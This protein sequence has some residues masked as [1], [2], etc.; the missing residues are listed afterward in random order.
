VPAALAG[1]TAVRRTGCS[2]LTG[3]SSSP[4]S[5]NK[6]PPRV[7][8]VDDAR[9]NREAY[10]E[11]LR[12]RG[13]EVLEASTGAE[14]VQETA[15][16]APDVVLLDMRLPDTNGGQV[17]REL[18]AMPGVR[19]TII[20]VSACT[21]ESDVSAALESGCDAFLAKPCLP[22]TLEKE[23]RRHLRARAVA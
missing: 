10:A 11:Y 17:C 20:A 6:R 4:V 3:M 15:R 13:F 12:F 21:F 16:S 19:P 23:I 14:A 5:N 8:I 18:R 7:L 9:D 22:Q 1:T 2:T